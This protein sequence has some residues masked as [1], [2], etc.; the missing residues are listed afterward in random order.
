[1]FLKPLAAF[2]LMEELEEQLKAMVAHRGSG[3]TTSF[4]MVAFGAMGMK[5]HEA[6]QAAIEVM[7]KQSSPTWPVATTKLEDRLAFARHVLRIVAREAAGGAHKP[8]ADTNTAN[9]MCA[10]AEGY[11][12]RHPSTPMV[13][14]A[15]LV[16]AVVHTM[17]GH[18]SIA[19]G[20]VK[21]LTAAW[22][23]V[24]GTLHAAVQPHVQA[25]MEAEL[26]AMQQTTGDVSHAAT[27]ALR[28][29]N[30]TAS[31]PAQAA[32][33]QAVAQSLMQSLQRL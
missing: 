25:P 4:A 15:S 31:M 33:D 11:L 1:M 21:S 5:D 7:C 13:H 16:S 27:E 19:P 20:D 22:G 24:G 9:R 23:I 2:R 6:R 26:R 28:G 10:A 3:A 8:I 14:V 32:H 30:D 18:T 12:R 17:P 29:N